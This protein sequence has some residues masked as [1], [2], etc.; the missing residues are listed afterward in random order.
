MLQKHDLKYKND[1]QNATIVSFRTSKRPDFGF[2]ILIV[3]K[4][5]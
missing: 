3:I 1:K 2:V 4:L 5:W